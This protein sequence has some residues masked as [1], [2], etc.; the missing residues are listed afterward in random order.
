MKIEK[1]NSPTEVAETLTK[2]DRSILF[3]GPN[4]D[5][6]EK[7]D[8][9]TE[10]GY[11]V[12]QP[13]ERVQ[14]VIMAENNSMTSI[15][16]KDFHWIKYCFQVDKFDAQAAYQ[17]VEENVREAYNRQPRAAPSPSTSV[18]VLWSTDIKPPA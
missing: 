7:A 15:T 12:R 10:A 2:Y 6:D 13:N 1:C 3:L 18:A 14:A 11:D 17:K 16:A 9:D 4:V 5:S 8:E